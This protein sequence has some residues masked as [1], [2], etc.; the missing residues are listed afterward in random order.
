MIDDN[1]FEELVKDYGLEYLLE[2][3]DLTPE[4]VLKFLYYEGQL[5]LPDELLYKDPE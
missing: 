2:V 1:F 4:D 3:S 5:W